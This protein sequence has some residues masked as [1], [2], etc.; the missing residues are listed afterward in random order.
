MFLKFPVVEYFTI[1]S[2]Q[3]METAVDCPCDDYWKKHFS[4][5]VSFRFI[6]FTKYKSWTI[7]VTVY[8]L[9]N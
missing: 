5:L 9:G 4:K 1:K 2:E 8:T 7:G 3:N 6:S